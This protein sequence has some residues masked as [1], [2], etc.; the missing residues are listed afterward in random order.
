MLIESI[1]DLSYL[2]GLSLSLIILYL[3]I[4]VFGLIITKQVFMTFLVLIVNLVIFVV[5][6]NSADFASLVIILIIEAALF[7]KFRY[8]YGKMR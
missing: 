8:L 6:F 7:F 2:N 1:G 5:A 4:I 3:A